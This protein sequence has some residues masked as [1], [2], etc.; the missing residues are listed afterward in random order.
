[1]SKLNHFDLINNNQCFASVQEG[2]RY[3][4]KFHSCGSTVQDSI[5][6]I[7]IITSI[8]KLKYEKLLFSKID[9]EVKFNHH[10]EFCKKATESSI[11]FAWTGIC[12]ELS[13]KTEN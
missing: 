13:K 3:S 11:H 12:N 1:M 9:Q 5:E 2:G 6:V 8:S 7:D 4:Y 10:L